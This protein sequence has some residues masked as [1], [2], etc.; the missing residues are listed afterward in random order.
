[1]NPPFVLSSHTLGVPSTTLRLTGVKA[2]DC[3]G[4]ER[5]ILHTLAPEHGIVVLLA[6]LPLVDRVHVVF[7]WP[8]AHS[9]PLSL[10]HSQPP[11]LTR[12]LSSA[13]LNSRQLY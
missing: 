5:P 9:L 13:A 4:E 12:C 8:K 11:R 2:R 6:C 3:R 10:Y 1:M 7:M